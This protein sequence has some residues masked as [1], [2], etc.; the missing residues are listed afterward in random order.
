L[1]T[2]GEPALAAPS[3]QTSRARRALIGETVL[4]AV[5]V[6]ST[7][8]V[9]RQQVL[10]QRFSVDESR[11]IATSRYFWITFVERDV[12]G[13]DWQPGYIV[14]THPPVARYV[15]GLGLWLQGWSP[16]ELNGRYDT[17]RSREFNI[18]AGNIPGPELL[19]AARRVTL[20]FGVGA[21]LLLY[22]IGRMMAGPI[23]GA[24]AVVLALANP[25]LS[26]LWTR[27]L[28]ESVLAFFSLL[29][30]LLAGLMS[31]PGGR[32]QVIFLQAIGLGAAVALATAT[33]LTGSLVALGLALFVVARAATRWSTDGRWSGLAPW[34][35]AGLT[36]M[37][38]FVL[39]NPLLYP[40]PLGRTVML[41]EHRREEMLQQGIGTPRLAV[42]DDITTRAGLMFRRTFLDW[43]TFQDWLGVPLDVPLTVLGLA[44]TVAVTWRSVRHHLPLGPPT[45]L[46]CW[47]LSTYVV[48]T[49]NLGFDSSHYFAM[50]VTIAVLLEAVAVSILVTGAARIV[51]N[52][53][54]RRSPGR[55]TSP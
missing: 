39:V 23:A 8:L 38:T 45:L 37:L 15:I 44:V 24:A 35:D 11:W 34:I 21:V 6:A 41:L 29:A 9:L 40:N 22:P 16:D 30:I 42:A 10:D 46:L 48:S 51:R 20:L 12:L 53:G 52:M 55:S 36:A 4:V 28:A 26:T 43:G 47:S 19:A 7:F 18:R 27:A 3:I 50:P 33:K 1:T 2:A 49:A 5:L 13:P 54:A 32:A 25:L 14:L 31:R 17:D